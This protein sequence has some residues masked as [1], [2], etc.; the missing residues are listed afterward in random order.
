MA[1]EN[2]LVSC[3]Q[4][5]RAPNDGAAFQTV[6]QK[7]QWSEGR[8]IVP[9]LNAGISIECGVPVIGPLRDQLLTPDKVEMTSCI[10]SDTLA[11]KFSVNCFVAPG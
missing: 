6:S 7:Q 8:Q 1:H 2:A 11:S 3:G 5:A 4:E 10:F 9:L